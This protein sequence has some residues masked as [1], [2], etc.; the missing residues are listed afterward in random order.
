MRYSYITIDGDNNIITKEFN[1]QI[2]TYVELELGLIQSGDI[3]IAVSDDQ[4]N[5]VTGYWSKRTQIGSDTMFSIVANL[6]MEHSEPEVYVNHELRVVEVE[7]PL[8]F[9]LTGTG[10][11]LVFEFDEALQAVYVEYIVKTMYYGTY[12]L[13]H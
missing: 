5:A 4:N 6:N 2:N 3:I 11:E 7:L 10:Y 13:H 12:L 1:T 9:K 8:T